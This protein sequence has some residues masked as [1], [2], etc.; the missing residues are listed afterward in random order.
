MLTG[1]ETTCERALSSIKH[2]TDFKVKS[3]NCSFVQFLELLNVLEQS[4]KVISVTPKCFPKGLDRT[5]PSSGPALV[6]CS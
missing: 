5:L 6:T 1:C 4:Q 2:G 3:I